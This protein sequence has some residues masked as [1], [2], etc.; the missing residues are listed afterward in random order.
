MLRIMRYY[1]L[2]LLIILIFLILSEDTIDKMSSTQARNFFSNEIDR[3]D[4]Q[5]AYQN[6]KKQAAS[7]N[8]NTQH[9]L[10]HIFGEV[11]F[12]KLGIGGLP[13]CDDAF[14]YGCYHSLVGQA[15]HKKGLGVIPM[16]GQ[17]CMEL[18]DRA[19]TGCQHGMGHGILTN[20]GYR[21][22][23]LKTALDYCDN[24]TERYPT[25]G[26]IGGVFMEYN[27]QTMLDEQKKIRFFDNNNTYYPCVKVLEKYRPSCYFWQAEWWSEVLPGNLEE[28]YTTIGLL[29][30]S[31]QDQQERKECYLGAGNI[32]GQHVNWNREE[33]AKLCGMIADLEGQRFCKEGPHL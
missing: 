25:L 16:L 11:L 27:F 32:A 13:V 28:R 8:R 26:C 21:F 1:L 17:K 9:R 7:A 12:N 23:D 2:I 31:L 20:L 30:G 18:E 10:A 3:N 4:A 6:F 24:L 33:A 29:C 15:I 22:E 19:S 14:S 5:E